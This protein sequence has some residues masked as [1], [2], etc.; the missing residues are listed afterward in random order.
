MRDSLFMHQVIEYPPG[1]PFLVGIATQRDADHIYVRSSHWHEDLEFTCI[2][3]G[4]AFYYI[5]GQSIEAVSGDL[6]VTNCGSVH[7]IQPCLEDASIYGEA[8]VVVLLMNRH[9]LESVFPALQ[10]YRFTND[11]VQADEKL[12]GIMGKLAAYFEKENHAPH[13]ALWMQSLLLQMIADL[14]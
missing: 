10:N 8:S 5:D 4:H 6:I 12:R 1:Q 13:E 11:Q 7:H 3:G 9:Y 14:L 2:K